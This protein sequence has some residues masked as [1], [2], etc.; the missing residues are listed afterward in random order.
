VT[1]IHHVVVDVLRFLIS[2]HRESYSTED[3]IDDQEA[4]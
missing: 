3:E 4:N 1:V 2:K